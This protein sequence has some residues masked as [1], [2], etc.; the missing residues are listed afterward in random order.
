MQGRLTKSSP[1]ASLQPDTRIFKL[2]ILLAEDDEMLADAVFRTLSQSAHL[3]DIA[4]DGGEAIH[5]LF[6]ADYDLLILDIGL[7]VLDGLEVLRRL[8][9]KRPELPVLMLSVRDGIQDRVTGLDLGADDYLTKPFHLFELE[10]RVRALIRRAHSPAGLEICHGR[11]RIDLTGRR[12][13]CDGHAIDLTS[14][15]FAL[16]ELLFMRIGR[17]VTKQQIIDQLY[18]WED[19]MASNAVEVLVHRLR[20][21]LEHS[22][23]NIQTIR[24]MGYLV[25]HFV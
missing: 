22:N 10:A 2:R 16:V 7:P 14:R 9:Q 13:Y 24:G 6:S 20:K 11:L 21:K 12:L 4:R 3:V 19:G 25:D 5:A 8:R 18:G 17:V 23:C 15:E 1:I